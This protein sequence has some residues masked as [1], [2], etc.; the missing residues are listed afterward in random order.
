M[1]ITQVAW[2]EWTVEHIARHGVTPDEVEE[3]LF[4]RPLIQRTRG[5]GKNAVYFAR[6]QTAAGR[7]LTIVFRY[8]G[9]QQARVITARDMSGSERKGYRGRI[10]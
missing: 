9:S 7:Y 10:R 4:A 3:V 6:G 5:R 8:L 2:D 1:R